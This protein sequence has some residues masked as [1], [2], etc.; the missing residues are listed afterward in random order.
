MQ[1]NAKLRQTFTNVLSL[2]DFM[3]SILQTFTTNMRPSTSYKDR[4]KLVQNKVQDDIRV[5][6]S[7][8]DTIIY[9]QAVAAERH[10]R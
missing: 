10:I 9:T 7:P 6:T 8:S 2:V 4:G 3:K 5:I 1:C